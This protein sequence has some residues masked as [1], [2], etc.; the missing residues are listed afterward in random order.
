MNWDSNWPFA[1]YIKL[2]QKIKLLLGDKCK[3]LQF[4]FIYSK[5]GQ[6]KTNVNKIFCPQNIEFHFSVNIIYT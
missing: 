5:M 6:K 2:K 4:F 1:V 3:I